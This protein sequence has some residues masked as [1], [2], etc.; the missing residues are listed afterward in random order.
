M[1]VIWVTGAKGFIGRNLCTY[2]SRKGDQV[3]GLGHGAWPSELAIESGVSYSSYEFHQ[4]A[5]ENTIKQDN[6]S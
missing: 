2:L 6:Q 5:K 1:S 4:R 3:L